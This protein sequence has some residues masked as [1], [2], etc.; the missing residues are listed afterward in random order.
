MSNVRAFHVLEKSVLSE[1]DKK[2]LKT[3][4]TTLSEVSG[5][6]ES[7]ILYLK[8]IIDQLNKTI[9]KLEDKQL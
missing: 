9:N 4:I 6:L 7:H 1:K 8:D 2:F 3:H 5:D